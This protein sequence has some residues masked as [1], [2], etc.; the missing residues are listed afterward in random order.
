[1]VNSKKAASGVLAFFRDDNALL[2]AAGDTYKAGYREFDSFSPFPIHGMDDA[3]GVKRSFLPWVTL[4]M[5][6]VGCGSGLLLQ[7][8]TSA[9]DWAVIV[10]GKSFFS[11]PAFIP[12]TFELTILF[13]A[14]GTVAAL[15]VVCGL[16]NTKVKI[17]DP[18]LT[19][20]KFA[21]FIPDTEVGYDPKKI[22]SLMKNLG[23]NE[24]RVVVE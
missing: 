8:Y 20:H 6:A 11:Y 22:E 12:V 21:L 1:M 10:G 16:P 5:G 18:D 15:F 19:S 23:S 24:V 17:H 2:K 3:M 7:W 9:Y 4:V 13:A 14:L